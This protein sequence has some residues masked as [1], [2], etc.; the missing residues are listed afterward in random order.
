[1]SQRLL[2]GLLVLATVVCAQRRVDPRNIYHRVITVVPYVGQGTAADPKRPQYAP[3]PVAVTGSQPGTAPPSGAASPTPPT[4]IGYMHVASDDGKYAIVELVSRD[5][6][7]F[8]A[9]LSDKSLT[10]FVKGK[11]SKDAIET[12]LRKYKKDF[13]LDKFGV[14]IP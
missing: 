12:A 6:A 1:M 13:S 11:D 8:N 5:M 10:V 4:I 14:V 9:V 3:L 2:L 7:A